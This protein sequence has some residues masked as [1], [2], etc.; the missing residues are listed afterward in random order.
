MGFLQNNRCASVASVNPGDFRVD[1]D[2]DSIPLAKIGLIDGGC[3]GTLKEEDTNVFESLSVEVFHSSDCEREAD[4]TLGPHGFS[5][6]SLI[7]GKRK[8]VN[9]FD[10][11]VD[12]IQGVAP[13]AP[14]HTYAVGCKGSS[15]CGLID[16]SIINAIDKAIEDGVK[17]ISMSIGY[18]AEVEHQIGHPKDDEV[19][20]KLLYATEKKVLTVAAIGNEGPIKGSAIS[21]RPWT[22]AVGACTNGQT[23]ETIVEIAIKDGNESFKILDRLKGVSLNVI[24]TPFL[25]LSVDKD[26][27]RKEGFL[28]ASSEGCLLIPAAPCHSSTLVPCFSVRPEVTVTKEQMDQL[29]TLYMKHGESL[30][31]RFLKSKYRI[32]DRNNFMSNFSSR[33]PSK[34]YEDN[35]CPDT[36]ALGSAVLM[37]HPTFV[38]LKDVEGL[39]CN[40]II[41]SG[42]SY[43]CPLVAAYALIVYSC[44]PKW[45]PFAVKS[46]LITTASS[47]AATCIP[48]SEF[49]YGAGSINLKSALKPGLVYDESW[50]SFKEYV[51]VDHSRTI[52]D[53][54][55]PTFS[56][57]F[58]YSHL[59]CEKIF[60][61]EL[62]NVGESPEE[63]T[64]RFQLFKNTLDPEVE[65][66][67][68]PGSLKFKPGEKKKFDLYVRVLPYSCP[69]SELSGMI[70]WESTTGGQT[71]RS[72]IHLYHQ[73]KIDKGVWYKTDDD[74]NEMDE[75]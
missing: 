34:L 27:W 66:R 18:D 56:A 4:A 21:G 2:L 60:K 58:S 5:C 43:A 75:D 47:F 51:D 44:H 55:L 63:Y 14:L 29:H 32:D 7:C 6:A 16:G 23:L 73:S 13:G 19:G 8:P 33:G 11:C 31:V 48:G 24:Q 15:S 12:Y 40:C 42:T 26:A 64:F 74:E 65:I 72:P 67:A 62:T 71:V 22:M 9:F 54:N 35:M 1:F 39:Y 30:F 17:V 45:S 59:S 28:Q 49:A 25:K 20:M 53:L 70:I 3:I 10:V 36:V 46:A 57:S 52:F 61:R 38:P 50:D 41:D 37:S 69:G 68:I